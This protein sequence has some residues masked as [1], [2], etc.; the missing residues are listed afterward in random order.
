MRY[1]TLSTWFLILS[2][3]ILSVLTLAGGIGG[4]VNVFQ[5]MC[6]GRWETYQ[7]EEVEAEIRKSEQRLLQLTSHL[8]SSIVAMDGRALFWFGCYVIMFTNQ[9]N[10]GR[11]N[12]QF[13]LVVLHQSHGVA[14]CISS[15]NLRICIR[16][17]II[18]FAMK[19]K[20]AVRQQAYIQVSR[21]R[22]YFSASFV[23]VFVF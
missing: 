23:F 3:Q 20:S 16:R 10:P 1:H 19:D 2:I 15:R 4:G 22:G 14:R 17:N 6:S 12:Y 13:K 21:F 5:Y 11:F 8:D 9:P 18:S 7:H